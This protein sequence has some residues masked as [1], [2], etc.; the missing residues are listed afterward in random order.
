MTAKAMLAA[1]RKD[2]GVCGRPNRITRDYAS[3]HG[4]AFLL[5]PWC[6]MSITRWAR[7]SGNEAAVLPSGDRAFTI[8]H[9]EDGERL[10]RWY[11][12]TT[13]NIRKYAKPGAIVFF[14]WSGRDGI[15]PID[16]VGIVERNLGDGRV[17]TIEGNTADSCKRRVRAANVVAGFWNPPY[18]TTETNWMEALVKKLPTLRLG[19][20]R[21]DG[22]PL[23]WHVKTMHY[24]LLARDYALDPKVD[25]TV[26]TEVH[27]QGIRGLQAAAG[28]EVDSIVGPD[29]WAVLL[30]VA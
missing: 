30:R 1:A 26:F 6:D 28:I 29:T 11:A 20:G 10:G 17:Q 13:A 12:G 7:E 27:A 15:P 14:D 4:D 2:L 18:G 19:D 25:D 9:A 21:K 24:L 22:D 16:H 3:R 23:K 5:A 8:W